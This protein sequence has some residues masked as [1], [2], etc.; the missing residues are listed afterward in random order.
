MDDKTFWLLV[1][2]TCSVYYTIKNY[3]AHRRGKDF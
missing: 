3:L 2:I 1:I